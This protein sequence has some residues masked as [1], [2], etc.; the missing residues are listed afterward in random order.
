[1][2]ENAPHGIIDDDGTAPG[3]DQGEGANSLGYEAVSI[4]DPDFALWIMCPAGKVKI[5]LRIKLTNRSRFLN[6]HQTLKVMSLVSRVLEAAYCK[7]T[8]HKLAFHALDYLEC[9]EGERWKDLF[10]SYHAAYLR[11]S[12]DPDK[13]FKDFKNHVLH[14][15]GDLWGGAP[16]EAREW[17]E[18]TVAA[19]EESNWG[20]AVYSAGVLS[21]YLT[22]PLMP[23][24]TGQSEAESNIHRAFEWSVAKSYD[25]MKPQIDDF[26]GGFNIDA[27]CDDGW[28][29]KMVEEGA[30]FSN[31]DYETLIEE[32]DFAAG[33]K[34]PPAGLNQVCRERLAKHLGYARRL[35][36]YVLDRA[37][38][39]AGVSPPSVSLGLKGVLAALQIPVRWVT[40]KMADR[41][42]KKIVEAMFLEFSATGRVD[43]N[44]TED[45]RVI[46]DEM[47]KRRE[48]KGRSKA[49]DHHVPGKA[50][51]VSQMGIDSDLAT[52]PSIGPRTATH[53][54]K[55]GVS[56]V[57]EFLEAEPADLALRV[58][59]GY[60]TPDVIKDWQDQARLARQLPRLRGHDVQILVG[61]GVRSL[62]ALAKTDPEALLAKVTPF[63]ESEAG[64]RVVRE[65]DRPDLDEVQHW[66]AL[67]EAAV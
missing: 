6:C 12:K 2:S 35:H 9:A 4:H 45:V 27:S 54:E 11:G 62:A 17:F 30:R 23:F 34:D 37:I 31:Q 41:A 50:G 10:L 21:H 60:I 52:A 44:L 66:V 28:L 49:I 19:L 25:E 38:E 7:G 13:V 26:A 58:G 64:R 24:H 18:D 20:E 43:R 3:K 67:A 33:T 57:S 1:M 39:E 47:E 46:R 22:D 29:E 36:G 5:P 56:R 53:F 16:G 59:V 63:V 65:K 15:R 8:H 51:K 42:E 32:Y 61:S 14:V 48:L 40:A 55:V